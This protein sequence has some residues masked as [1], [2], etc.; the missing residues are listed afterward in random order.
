MAS[1]FILKR[2]QIRPPK[3]R[4]VATLFSGAARPRLT[5]PCPQ[6][7]PQAGSIPLKSVDHLTSAE[8]LDLV[9]A[10]RK[11]RPNARLRRQ[12]A[13]LR[14]ARSELRRSRAESK[15]AATGLGVR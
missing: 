14:Q 3:Q 9:E 10:S 6:R 4:Q 13:E 11:V 8:R 15:K 5:Y 12:F 2:Y 1:R 7:Y